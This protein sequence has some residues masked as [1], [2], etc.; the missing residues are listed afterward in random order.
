M[1]PTTGAPRD[2]WGS[3]LAFILAAAGSAVG[4]GNIWGFPTVAA[5]NGGG[6]FL[7]VYVLAVVLVGAPVM[8]AELAIGRRTQRNPVGA[9]RALRPGSA[10]VAVGGLGVL[11]GLMILSFYSVVGGWTMAYVVKVATGAI[12]PETDT[13]AVF[14]GVAG[15]PLAAI[16]WHLAF[17]ALTVLIVVGGVRGGIERWT[18]ILMPAL[19]GLLVLLVIRA[20]TLSG[21][22]AGLEFY[23]RPDFSEVTG[24]TIL[25]AIGQAFFSLSLGMG[26]MITYGSY[27]SKKDD[28]ET[29]ALYVTG[30]DTSVAFLAGLLIF[31]TLFHAGMDPGAGGPGMVFVVLASL[32]GTIPPAPWG[33]ILFGAAFFILLGIAAVTSSISLLEVIV[34]WIVDERSW[35][36]RKAAWT[37]G[38]LAFLIGIPSA[39]AGGAVG[40]L[41]SLPGVGMDFLSFMFALFGQYALVVGALFISIFAGWV[42]G[43]RAAGEEVRSND[44]EFSLEGTWS[45]LIRFLCPVAIAALLIYLVW[46]Q[47]G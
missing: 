12:R 6:A 36:R 7:V 28:L 20:V 4:L 43:A 18:K 16:G 2:T 41:T 15:S 45:F 10:W 37:F 26:A 3:K 17:M 47:V 9:F 14:A 27:V 30:F 13:A 38:A 11:T 29:S 34:A 24:G 22:G 39:L 44:G 21:A 23:L 8:L 35:A 32:L 1:E 46:Q 33:G 19:A 5:A 40:W 31:P 25:A 42:W